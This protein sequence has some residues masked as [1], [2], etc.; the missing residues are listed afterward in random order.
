MCGFC[1]S[2]PGFRTSA[3]G[4]HA[5]AEGCRAM[6]DFGATLRE[7]REHA[8]LTQEELGQLIGY[9]RTAVSRLESS[10]D[11]RLTPRILMQI[12]DALD[13][14]PVALLGAADRED[15]V[16]RRQLLQA[17]GSLAFVAA[18]SRPAP[19][20]IGMHDVTEIERGIEH[21]RVL[22][23][24]TGGD[25]LGYFAERLV[26]DAEHLLRGQLTGNVAVRLQSVYGEASVFAG[27]LA[28]DSG[29][30][31]SAAR[32]YSEA[33]TAAQLANDPLLTAHTCCNLAFLATRT[34]QST[35]AIQCAQAGQRAAVEG[36]GGPRLRALLAA[37]ESTGH[38]QLGNLEATKDLTHRALKAFDSGQGQDPDW[39]DFVSA[40]ELAG[41]LGNAHRHAGNYPVALQQLTQAAQMDGKP[42]NAASWRMALA[43]GYAVADDP[44]QAASVGAAVL[45]DVVALSSTRVR[46]DVTELSQRLRPHT[47]IREVRAFREQAELVGLTG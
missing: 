23:Q 39:V 26:A 24:S 18:T 40:T 30:L 6:T 8:G 20:R 41:I 36:R 37:R 27:W 43:L 46:N 28:Q 1:T 42:R 7:A 4:S 33:M 25:L 31:Q 15:P 10:P 17:A 45:P 38:A 2:V 44:G 29:D 14:H 3:C 11:P 12:G 5:F 22:D 21:L 35:K 47:R 32:H 16:N 13:V 19:G 34:G 9:S